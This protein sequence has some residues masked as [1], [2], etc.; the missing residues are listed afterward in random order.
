MTKEYLTLDHAELVP[1]EDLLH[2]PKDVFYLSIHGVFKDSSTTIKL[3]AVFDASA[4]SSS[5]MSLN[6]LLLTGPNL[7]PLLTTILTK[8]RLNRIAFSA[9]IS[10]MFQEEALQPR[11]RDFIIFSY[12]MT[13]DRSETT[14]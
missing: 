7:Y 3:H 1:N 9:D 6:D 8:F 2:P 10:K 11:D 13:R 4:S 5:G 12:A 14:T